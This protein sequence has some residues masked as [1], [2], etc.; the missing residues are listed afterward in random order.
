MI[1]QA[2]P[3]ALLA[4]LLFSNPSA[5]RLPRRE[6]A[7][8][9]SETVVVTSIVTVDPVP[10]TTAPGVFWP[11]YASGS[12]TGSGYRSGTGR[13]CARATGGSSYTGQ[14]TSRNWTGRAKGSVPAYTKATPKSSSTTASSSSVPKTTS[15]SSANTTSTSIPF[16]RGVNLGGWLILEKWLNSDVFQGNFANAAD[17][18]TFDSISGAETALETHWET[19]LTEID[20]QAIA[21]TGMNALRIPI[22]YWAYNNT[23]TP[24]VKGADAYLEKAI[25]WARTAGMKVWVDCHG[26]PGSQNGY[27]NSGHATNV[28]WQQNDNLARSIS[29]LKTMA[30]KYGAAKYADVVVGLELVNEPI[31]WGNNDFSTTQAWAKEAYSAVKAAAENKN[32]VIV[33]HDGFMGPLSWTSTAEE[34]TS[35][36]E[37]TFGVDTHLYQ[38]YTDADN[39]LTLQEHITEACGWGTNLSTSNAIM[40]TYVG[41]WSAAINICVD[42]DGTTTAGTTCST[43]GCQCQST[44]FD[45]WNDNM[46]AAVGKYVEAQLDTFEAS[47]SG[48]FIWTAKGPGGWGYF[49]D[50]QKGVFPNPVTSRKHSPQCKSYSRRRDERGFLSEF[51]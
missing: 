22:G 13:G 18:W 23:N 27:D 36:R 20:V 48:Y 21:A 19:Y 30:T 12:G 11:G 33:M 35:G 14:F 2:I 29:V 16:L 32:L 7:T 31:S 15:S 4:A 47:T 9:G 46:V 3:S 28:K 5:A 38:L 37:K 42:P 17:Q 39:A 50:I 8:T 10:L 6:T 34:L 51:S 41:E 25:G 1:L 44:S 45:D 40:P 49:N 43:Y 24:Y 26:S